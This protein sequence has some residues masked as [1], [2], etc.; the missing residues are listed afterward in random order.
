MRRASLNPSSEALR[1]ALD[2]R[3]TELEQAVLARAYGVADPTGA[4]DPQ[5]LD[6]LRNAVEAAI[7]YGLAAIAGDSERIPAIPPVVLIQA[8]LAARNRI[9]LDT[10][11][12]RYHGGN[13]LFSELLIEEADRCELPRDDLKRLFRLLACSFDTLLAAVS[14]EHSREA[15]ARMETTERRH[16]SVIERVLGGE[17]VGS[18]ELGYD[19]DANHLALV[20]SGRGAAIALRRVGESVDRRLLVAEPGPEIVWA[21]LG[22]HRPIDAREFELL[23]AADWGEGV[24]LACGEPGKGVV[25]WRLSHRQ[26]AAALPVAQRVSQNL[27]RYGDVALLASVLQDDLLATSLRQLYLTPL[28]QERNQGAIAKATLRAYFAAGGNASSAGV[29]LGVS[30]RTVASRLATI[31]ERLGRKVE[32][33]SAELETVLR[34]EE[35]EAMKEAGGT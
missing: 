3:R 22:G 34:L 24:A 8:R 30:R 35:I 4:A 25:G 19:L 33:A 6:G 1:E 10:V 15:G 14:E 31:E 28:T 29:A 27:V 23:V 21:W 20:A 9:S 7:G 2:R 32:A 26:A 12:R 13:T 11:L 17:L 16:L 5:Y 18:S